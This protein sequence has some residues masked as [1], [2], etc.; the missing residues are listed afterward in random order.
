MVEGKAKSE[1]SEYPKAIEARKNVNLIFNFASFG[2]M[3]SDWIVF[4]NSGTRFFK[5]QFL[6]LFEGTGLPTNQNVAEAPVG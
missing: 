1:P 5:N 2:A 3:R 4:G 6:L